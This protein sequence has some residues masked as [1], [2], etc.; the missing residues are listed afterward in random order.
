MSHTPNIAPKLRKKESLQISF[1]DDKSVIINRKT[2]LDSDFFLLGSIGISFLILGGIYGEGM[3][4]IM[5]WFF[6]GLGILICVVA[7]YMYWNWVG[8]FIS[9]N[10]EGVKSQFSQ[11]FSKEK[12]YCQKSEIDIFKVTQ[13]K[14]PSR[15]YNR[16]FCYKLVLVKKNAEEQIIMQSCGHEFSFIGSEMKALADLLNEKHNY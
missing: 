8:F 11:P 7:G 10:D 6:K 9:L 12:F 1:P 5:Q 15:Q 4:L 13:E 2:G 16:A 14:A 3:P